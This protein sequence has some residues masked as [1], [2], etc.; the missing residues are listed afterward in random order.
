MKKLN[1]VHQIA[2]SSIVVSIQ[3]VLIILGFTFPALNFLIHIL[4]PIG[5]IIIVLVSDKSIITSFMIASILMSTLFASGS[6]EFTLVFVLPSLLLGLAM[7]VIL[8]FKLGYFDLFYYSAIIQTVIIGLITLVTRWLY[9]L[10]LLTLFYQFIPDQDA[11]ILYKFDGLIL[12]IFSLIQILISLSFI[13]LILERLGYHMDYQVKPHKIT[14]RFYNTLLIFGVALAF[15]S[16]Y[17]SLFFLGPVL[18]Y[19]IYQYIYY[20]MRY[21]GWTQLILIIGLVLFPFLNSFSHLIWQEGYQILSI[22]ILAIPPLCL[23]L[24]KSLSKT[25]INALI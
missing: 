23:R 4:F 7:G 10:D 17:V 22:Y 6:F 21:Q 14:I 12:Y 11:T 16:P 1:L 13:P 24:L 2:L 18:Y 9:Q 15:I 8:N 25:P 19:F 5:T 3:A 20:L